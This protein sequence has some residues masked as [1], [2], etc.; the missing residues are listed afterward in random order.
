MRRE[1]AVALAILSFAPPRDARADDVEVRGTRRASSGTTLTREEV[2]AMP[3]AFGDPGRIIEA[4][5]GVVPIGTALP[6]YFVRGATP[7]T[8]GY[9]LDGM[10]IPLFSHGPPGGGVVADSAIERV[11][12]YPGAA[13]A[14][15]GGTTGGVLSVTTAPPEGRVRGAASA[16]LY[17]SSALFEVPL[18]K[19][20]SVLAS[21]RYGYTQLLLDVLAPSARQAYWD[22]YAR[23]TLELSRGERLSVVTVGA[24][25]FAGEAGS[26]TPGGR[27]A[28]D[29]TIVDSTFHR[30]ELRYDVATRGGGSVRVAATT[31]VNVQGNHV[32]AVSD[33]LLGVR[34]EAVHPLGD[35]RLTA[36]ASA[37]HERYDVEVRSAAVQQETD[38]EILFAPRSDLSLAAYGELSWRVSRDVEL[39]G[40]VRIG[41]FSTQRD[42]YPGVYAE[43]LPRGVLRPPAG[44]VT[45]LAVDPRLSARVRLA[46]GVAF[47]SAFGIARS[48]PTFL[49]PGLSMSR[50]EDGLQTAVQASSGVELALAGVGTARVTGFL[51]HYLDLSDPSATCPDHT[52]LVFNPTDPCFGRRVRGRAFGGEIL[53]RR[54]LT[55]RLSGWLSYTLSR[56]TRQAHAPGWAVFGAS[57]EALV[58]SPSEFDRTHTLS[59]MGSYDL[60]RGWRASAR[61]SYLTGRPYSRTA[62]GVLVGPYNRERLPA[63]H[64]LDLRLEKKWALGEDASVSLVF[65]WFN[66]TLYREVIE[67]R[68]DVLVQQAP[69]PASFVEGAPLDAC[70]FQRSTLFT[71]PSVGLEGRF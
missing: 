60:G 67:C 8:T 65:E 66:A 54:P 61:A 9:F 4:M 24:R 44:A 22:Y 6:F 17:D 35:V 34:M 3:G 56:S 31:G 70:R 45:K 2:H 27:A 37:M 52:G 33:R 63:V 13:P 12:F 48:P 30:A 49:L 21:G 57:Q 28:G 7:S 40:G 18:G 26:R 42:S 1:A 51:H 55:E 10:R 23:A 62:R 71:I 15:F 14:R 36:G 53:L 47:V 68:P 16:R 59:A 25:D 39:E 32:G 58:E 29:R 19:K 5:P 69:V 46:R 50:L 20:A 11:D 64:R 43:L 41:S 38:P